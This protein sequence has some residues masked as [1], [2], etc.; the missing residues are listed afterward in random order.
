MTGGNI[1]LCVLVAKVNEREKVREKVGSNG[2]QKNVVISSRLGDG[3]SETEDLRT[4]RGA[5]S[6]SG[7][8][9]GA[10]M[11]LLTGF[12][13]ARWATLL[14]SQ[15]QMGKHSIVTSQGHSA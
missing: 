9:R 4:F 14:I 3:G 10:G 2:E 12:V 13:F 7:E 11:L 15:L 6:L 5:S 1:R 8:L